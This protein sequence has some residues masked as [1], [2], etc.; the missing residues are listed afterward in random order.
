MNPT[1]T[2]R[3][4]TAVLAVL[5]ALALP[6]WAAD[7]SSGES[8]PPSASA[9]AGL[10]PEPAWPGLSEVQPTKSA[11]LRA[12]AEI[13]SSLQN[14]SAGSNEHAQ[15]VAQLLEQQQALLQQFTDLGDPQTWSGERLLDMQHLL[16]N[17]RKD[18]QQR[19][20]LISQQAQARERETL[21]WQERLD[22][23]Q[24]WEKELP[25]PLGRASRS[26]FLESR[27]AISEVLS[28]LDRRHA[29]LVALQQQVAAL[30]DAGLDSGKKISE[31]L[32]LLRRDLL[33]KSS[34]ALYTPRFFSALNATLL[35]D[36]RQGLQTA[37]WNRPNFYNR[38]LP[39]FIVQLTILLVV[40]ILIRRARGEEIAEEW[41]FLTARPLA[42]AIFAAFA[43]PVMFY[44][45]PPSLVALAT[46]VL[47][48]GSAAFLLPGLL[49]SRRLLHAFYLLIGV[50]FGKG[51]VD[52]LF[53]PLPLQRLYHVASCLLIAFVLFRF[54]R[55]GRH[56]DA[57]RHRHMA[58]LLLTSATFFAAA[59][60]QAI[61]FSALGFWISTLTVSTLFAAVLLLMALTLGRGAIDFLV[62]LA[63]LQQLR[64]F[65]RHGEA[66]AQRL[67]LILQIWL[68]FEGGLYI[69]V[70]WR[71]SPTREQAIA[72]LG[73]F[74]VSIGGTEVTLGML[75]WASLVMFLAFQVSWLTRNLIDIALTRARRADRGVREAVR[76]LIHYS[77]LAI[78]AALALT[79]AGVDARVFAVI[80]G[81]VG[82]GIGFGL[83]NIVNNFV[84]GIILL[85]ERP[86]KSGDAI[87]L[88]NEW[89]TVKKIGLRSTVVETLDNSEIIVPNSLL[90]SEKV[91]NWTLSTATA[92]VVMP[93]GVAYG[94]DIGQVL[95]LL[96]DAGNAHPQALN[97]P[98]VSAIF[99]GF[100]DSS[101]DFELRVWIANIRERLR[102]RSEIL[103]AV[104]EALNTAGIEIPFPQRDL[105]LRSID[106]KA[107]KSLRPPAKAPKA[108]AP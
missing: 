45:Q 73:E 11:L 107:A 19:L 99:I 28:A 22:Y 39:L 30:L 90:I 24:Q 38:H 4:C 63:P 44:E 56:P 21:E 17:Q 66:L 6:A 5:A 52:A 61:G 97:D 3:H 92:R 43:G 1:R 84:S 62:R 42:A 16:E 58:L 85:F 100:G 80:G 12:A 29:E 79:T 51:L 46:R 91:T 41:Q 77:L 68:M 10:A 25:Q 93:I 50:E 60:A 59:T 54:A 31:A 94:T 81:A 34:P 89:G 53:M 18:Q 49:K 72:T 76:K 65:S 106:A 23:W 20:Q 71:L 26:A 82:I 37:A 87:V 64:F 9:P 105:H 86:I 32:D 96:S 14:E 13:Q 69:L 102:V 103:H 36:I 55:R 67:K 70:I 57:P 8:P 35:T 108:K 7:E 48:L 83:Q 27:Q 101:L 75:A 2:L 88:D 40:F 95:T 98:P 74:G 78:G 47:T 104:A 33:R 15:A